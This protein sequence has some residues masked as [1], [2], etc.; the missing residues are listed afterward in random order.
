MHLPPRVRTA[1]RADRFA[2]AA[3]TRAAAL[4]V[5]ATAIA[6]GTLAFAFAPAPATAPGPQSNATTTATTPTAM[7]PPGAASFVVRGA[8]VFDGTRSLGV[9]DVLVAGGK[10]A[11]VGSS[12]TA[13]PGTP[14]VPGAGRTLLPGLIDSHTHAWSEDALRQALMLGVTTEL[15]M[16]SVARWAA[17]VKAAQAAGRDLDLADLRSAGTMA[18]APGGHG[19]EYGFEI[20]TLTRADQAPAWVDARLAEGSDYIKIIVEDGAITGRPLPTLDAATVAALVAAAHQRGKLAVVHVT[21]LAA[22]RQAIAAGADGL[23]HL[24]VDAPP[25]ADFG[26]FVAAHHAFVVPTLSVLAGITGAGQPWAADTGAGLAHDPRLAPYLSPDAVANLQGAFAHPAVAGASVANAAAAI[27]QLLAAGVPI[28]AGTDAPNPG[29]AH[30]AS[31]LGE[32]ALLATAGL[33]PQQALAAATSAPAAAFHLADRG[34]IA[35]GLRADLLLAD[36]DAI[37]DPR[38]VRAIVQVWKQGVAADRATFRAGVA[39]ATAIQAAMGPGWG[40]STDQ[41]AGGSSTAT[42]AVAAEAP[43][44]APKGTQSLAIRGTVAAGAFSW[45]GAALSPG[46]V[47]HAAADLSARTG[48]HFWA[49]G[50]GH[51]FSLMLF[52]KSRGRVP[53]LQT[54]TAGPQWQAFDFPWARFNAYDGHDV[55]LV[56]FAAVQPPGPFSLQLARVRLE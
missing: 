55:L 33:T 41:I 27:R 5:V 43:P 40:V 21:T 50:D 23:A 6:C 54:F 17:Q 13:P 16:G 26:R 48:L 49:K 11:A 15:D 10:I 35:P 47:P 3:R 51:T 56:V 31:A 12:L 25:D 38:R 2:R 52:A 45:A 39:A 53:L 37:A 46:A 36:G 32:I 14:E 4:A 29:T 28:L 19:T 8:L 44:D 22:A 24:F 30:G 42:L 18:T 1:T 34:R 7:A 20:P 9:A